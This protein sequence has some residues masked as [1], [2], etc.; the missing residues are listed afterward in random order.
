[1]DTTT[2][3]ADAVPIRAAV[4]DQGLAAEVRATMVLFGVVVLVTLGFAL[5]ST[6]A[7]RLLAS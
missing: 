2:A 5:A 7:L 4:V 3:D 1:M 6:L